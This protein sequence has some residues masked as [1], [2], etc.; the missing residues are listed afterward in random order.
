MAATG[1]SA[2]VAR[3]RGTRPAAVALPE[4]SVFPKT[5]AAWRAWLLKHHTRETGLW[6]VS[7]KKSSG[8]ARLTY[9]DMIEEAL[10][11][12]WIDG[13]ARGLDEERT[14]LWLSPRRPKSV[15]S[16]SN[17]DRV[18]RILAKGIVHPAGLA[19]I[20]EAKR[21]G[22]WSALDTIDRLEIP[23]DLAAAFATAGGAAANFEALSKTQKRA[24]LEWIRQA[25]RP[26]TRARRVAEAARMAARGERF[27]QAVAVRATRS[28]SGARSPERG[29]RSSR[30]RD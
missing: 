5:R 20:E 9:D 26:E 6:F 3:T 17:R 21:N 24:V 27:G 25:K 28:P 29:R 30:R 19:K 8:K 1:R 10:C 7:Y 14:M 4:N 12:G 23:D 2:S 13:M 22:T 16:A 11:F 15:W 18:A